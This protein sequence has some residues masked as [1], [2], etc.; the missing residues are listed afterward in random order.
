MLGGDDTTQRPSLAYPC[1]IERNGRKETQKL[2]PYVT[3]RKE[4]MNVQ[5]VE[6]HGEVRREDK[7]S[8]SRAV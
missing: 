5:T 4:G 7:G 2:Q 3:A 1:L 8:E 6:P